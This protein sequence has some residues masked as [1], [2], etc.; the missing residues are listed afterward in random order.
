MLTILYI[1][2]QQQQYQQFC[3]DHH[4]SSPFIFTFLD[5]AC[6]CLC[7]YVY[8]YFLCSND[9]VI[10]Q[11]IQNMKKRIIQNLITVIVVVVVTTTVQALI[12]TFLIR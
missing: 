12:K 7:M 3:Q 5:H 11:V 9:F 1:D 4:I 8:M 2:L 10:G 6:V